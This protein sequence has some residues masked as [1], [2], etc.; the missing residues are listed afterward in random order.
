MVAWILVVLLMVLIVVEL[1]NCILYREVR[2]LCKELMEIYY[3]KQEL[4]QRE[5]V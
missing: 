3:A 1:F 5:K 4:S 2:S